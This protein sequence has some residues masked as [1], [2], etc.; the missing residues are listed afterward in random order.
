[1]SRTV[2][3]IRMSLCNAT[4]RPCC[5]PAWNGMKGSEKRRTAANFS[6]LHS[7]AWISSRAELAQKLG[8]PA[9]GGARIGSCDQHD[10]RVGDRRKPILGLEHTMLRQ[11]RDLG[12]DAHT[13][14]DRD[15]GL[16]PEEARARIGH[17][18]GA[19]GGF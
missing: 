12:Q 13:D 7:V 17:V 15:R 8:E 14:A 2:L 3:I 16:D 4:P 10:L 11:D 19:S 18:P 5:A 1:M 6:C 9:S